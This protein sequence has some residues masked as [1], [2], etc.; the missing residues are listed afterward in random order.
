MDKI[1]VENAKGRS[2]GIVEQQLVGAKLARRFQ[3]VDI[4]NH[5]AHAP[6]DKLKEWAILRF[7]FG[8]LR[9]SRA[10]KKRFAEMRR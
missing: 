2:G 4:S 9:Y 8:L 7:K 10:I 5:P 1:I 3:G 6:T